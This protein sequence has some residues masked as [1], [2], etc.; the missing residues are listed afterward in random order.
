MTWICQGPRECQMLVQCLPPVHLNNR[1][2]QKARY[3]CAPSLTGFSRT[4]CQARR[5]LPVGGSSSPCPK[6]PQAENHIRSQWPKG[7][8]A[9][10]LRN[11]RCLQS[12]P[13]GKETRSQQLNI[14]LKGKI[15]GS[16]LYQ[17]EYQRLQ[18]QHLSA[19]TCLPH[20]QRVP[21]EGESYRWESWSWSEV[22]E[23]AIRRVILCS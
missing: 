3:Q 13:Q 11:F 8:E 21:H 16:D 22:E 2:L 12:H 6:V 15:Q 19:P 23:I 4:N 9:A 14:Q 20:L 5:F 18:L 10:T 17:L 7:L 1:R